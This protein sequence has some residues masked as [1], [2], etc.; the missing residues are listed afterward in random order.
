MAKRSD[1][2][3]QDLLDRLNSDYYPVGSKFPSDSLLA[4]EFGTTRITINKIA[5]LLAEQGYLERGNR[6]AG[7][8][9][10]PRLFRPKGYIAFLGK[11]NHFSTELLTGI[12][13]ECLLCGY[14]TIVLSPKVE[15]LPSCLQ[16]LHKRN[17]AGIISVGYGVHAP[18]DG[19]EMYCLDCPAALQTP[20]AHVHFINSDNYAGGRQIM[21]EVLRRNHRDIV[22][23]SLSHVFKSRSASP[24]PL[25]IAPRL[26]GMFDAMK[27]AGITD[28]AKRIFHGKSESLADARESFREILRR[29]PETTVICTDSDIGAEQINIVAREHGIKCPGDIALTGFG[30]ITGLRIASVDQNAVRQGQLAA[31]YLIDHV[32]DSEFCFPENELVETTVS[33]A[34]CIPTLVSVSK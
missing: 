24:T 8:R 21:E 26:R 14:F 1:Q 5:S 4:D 13:T 23:F 10:A 2:I 32:E 18:P 33:R 6:G 30:N 34:D 19:V 28:C 29:Y 12:Q 3:Y 7:T 11:L 31:R 27:Q 9:V 20:T 17:A 22:V 15:E 16:M 25:K